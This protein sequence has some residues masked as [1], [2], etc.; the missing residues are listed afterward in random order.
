MGSEC[1]YSVES[2]LILC[3]KVHEGTV[4]LFA[5]LMHATCFFFM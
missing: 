2:L 1:V 3:K 5:V 4:H